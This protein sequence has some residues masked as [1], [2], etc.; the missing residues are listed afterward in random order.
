MALRQVVFWLIGFHSR[1]PS[2]LAFLSLLKGYWRS[3]L[4]KHGAR[5]NRWIARKSDISL[6]ELKER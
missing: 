1:T 4:E 2:R 5:L 6:A 3:R